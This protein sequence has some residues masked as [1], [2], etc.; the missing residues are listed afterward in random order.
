MG[1]KRSVVLVGDKELQA[2]ISN[3]DSHMGLAE[4]EVYNSTAKVFP[5]E[6]CQLSHLRRLIYSEGR[7]TTIPRVINR[8]QR[9]QHLDLSANK[10]STLPSSLATIDSSSP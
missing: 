7:I 9:L 6:I 10:L 2:F 3:L 5:H 4:I 8:L 1:R